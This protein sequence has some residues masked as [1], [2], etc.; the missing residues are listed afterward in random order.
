MRNIAFTILLTTLI[1]GCAGT[2]FFLRQLET[3]NALRTEPSD[4]PSY[5]YKVTVKN[6]IDFNFDGDK[7][8]DRQKLLEDMFLGQCKSVEI[9][10]ETKIQTGTYGTGRPTNYWT[11]KVKCHR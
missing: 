7:R 8:E 1:T 5:D 6:V 2:Q 9:L 10:D 11:M 3:S 4:S